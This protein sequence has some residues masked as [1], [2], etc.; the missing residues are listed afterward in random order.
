MKLLIATLTILMAFA[1][2]AKDECDANS[3]AAAVAIETINA[4][5]PKKELKVLSHT[6]LG[7]IMITTG[8]LYKY[9]TVLTNSD[10]GAKSYYQTYLYADTCVVQELNKVEPFVYNRN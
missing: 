7:Q 4:N 2:Y 3:K 10:K 9:E 5:I 6:Y 8:Y 1:S